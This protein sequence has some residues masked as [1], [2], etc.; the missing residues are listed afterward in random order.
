MSA[1]AGGIG[2]AAKTA[3]ADAAATEKTAL[4]SSETIDFAFILH[5]LP[6]AAFSFL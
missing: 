6:A 4:A 1:E 5:P 2:S 3:D